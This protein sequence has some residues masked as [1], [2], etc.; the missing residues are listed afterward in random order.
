MCTE[1]QQRI[2]ETWKIITGKDGLI[3]LGIRVV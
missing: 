1:G 3:I 2:K